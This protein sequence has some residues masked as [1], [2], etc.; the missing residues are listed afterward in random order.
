MSRK[1]GIALTVFGIAALLPLLTGFSSN[2]QAFTGTIYLG[3]DT[4]LTGPQAVRPGGPRDG[5]GARSVLELPRRHQGPQARG[6]HARQRVQSLP[7]RPERA[8]VRGRLQVRRD[9]RLGERRG[10]RRDRLVRDTGQDPVHRALAADDACRSAAAV[11]L[12]RSADLEAVR[13]QH[14]AVPAQARDQADRADG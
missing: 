14:G 3:M 6:R 13:V 2:K 10:G 8:A 1:L 4:P 5:A 11:R 9:P 7:G 12:S